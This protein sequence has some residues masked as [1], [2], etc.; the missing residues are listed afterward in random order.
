LVPTHLHDRWVVSPILIFRKIDGSEGR[1]KAW[2]PGYAGLPV[3]PGA[4]ALDE[5]LSAFP[6]RQAPVMV[7]GLLLV[8]LVDLV[9]QGTVPLFLSHA[10]DPA[11]AVRA[12]DTSADKAHL[13]LEPFTMDKGE[14]CYKPV[15]SFYEA[16]V[17]GQGPGL[18]RP[19]RQALL[20]PG[21]M[22]YLGDDTIY[23]V[24]S[25]PLSKKGFLD[26]L[27]RPGDF[28][29]VRHSQAAALHRVP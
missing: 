12:Q 29:L 20:C 5:I 15:L 9:N 16:D 3:P 6:D 1:T 28:R 8:D 7:A 25:G 4:E 17:D 18:G 27:G 13:G 26:S 24:R 2:G 23:P 19:V 22:L 10:S 11:T 21:A 14:P